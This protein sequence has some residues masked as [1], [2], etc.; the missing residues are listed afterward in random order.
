[1]TTRNP[2]DGSAI[3]EE[4]EWKDIHDY[5]QWLTGKFHFYIVGVMK[6]H[7]DPQ[8]STYPK[9]SEK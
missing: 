9:N 3:I 5:D 4:L 7:R 1:M 2:L 6:I 8:F